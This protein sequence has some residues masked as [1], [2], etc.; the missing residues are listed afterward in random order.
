MHE[1][2][3]TTGL[4]FNE[5]LIWEKSGPG[6]AGFSLPKADTPEYPLDPGLTGETPDFP[7]VSEVDI[8]RHF[9]RLSQWNYGVD[10][11][12]YPLGSCTMKYN[13]KTNERQANLPGFAQSHP[14]VPPRLLRGV[15]GLLYDLERFLAEITGMDAVSLQPSAGAQG[16]LTGIMLIKAYFRSMGEH[17]GKIIIPDTA[18]GTNPASVALSGF[19]PV[20][21]KTGDRGVLTPDVVREIMSDDVAGI[22][23][24]N[25]NTLGLFEENI[26]EITEIVHSH[27]GQV[28]CDGANL[29]ALMGI[30][31]VG[32]TGV[33]VM[34]VNLHKTFS[35]P[36]G[37]GGPGSGPVCV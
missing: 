6:R 27:G 13:P 10:S 37:G 23:I 14:L 22:M 15:L 16:E 20:P 33:D 19:Q 1:T 26:R 8:V 31:Q 29:N 2:V 21:V 32:A 24:T 7:E 36:H 17:R 9:T 3:G 4:V 34:H 12:M 30:V 11:G 35:S 18:H 25:P 5:P 28:Y